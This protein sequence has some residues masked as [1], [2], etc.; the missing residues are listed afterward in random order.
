M[1]A[2]YWC[3]CFENISGNAERLAKEIIMI[4]LE[5]GADISMKSNSK[6]I[7]S[8]G[9]MGMTALHIACKY[10]SSGVAKLIIDHGADMH[11]PDA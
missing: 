7:G 1:A 11:L 10:S 9:G 2:V 8:R 5:N 3:D 6:G 4:L